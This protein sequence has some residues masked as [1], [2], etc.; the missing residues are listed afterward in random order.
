[1]EVETAV[2]GSCVRVLA[3]PEQGEPDVSAPLRKKATLLV[4]VYRGGDWSGEVTVVA[5]S[6]SDCAEDG[7]VGAFLIQSQSVT[8]AFPADGVEELTL[9]IKA[10]DEDADGHPAGAEDCDDRDPEVFVGN[11]AERCTDSKDKNCSGT[12]GCADST[13]TGGCD[14]G[15]ACTTSDQCQPGGTCS[16]SA[17][18]C[19]SPPVC[20]GAPGTCDPSDGGCVYPALAVSTA[21]NDNNACSQN[22]VCQ[23]DAT[24]GGGTAVTCTAP[25]ECVVATCNLAS[26]CQFAPGNENVVC[27]GGKG[28]CLAGTCAFNGFVTPGTSNFTA[29]GGLPLG[30]VT[31]NCLSTLDTAGATPTWTLCNGGQISSLDGGVRILVQQSG[32]EAVL[33]RVNDFSLTDAGV[34]RIRGTRPVIL[35]VYGDALIGGEVD[36]GADALPAAGADVACNP[37]VNGDRTAAQ[38][39]GGGGGGAFAADGGAGGRGAN[40]TP[41]GLG[42]TASGIAI[43]VPLRGGCGGGLGGA[44]LPDKSPGGFGGGALQLSAS[45]VVRVTGIINANGGGGAGAKQRAV[46]EDDADGAGGGGS[47]GAILLEGGYVV[48]GA[49]SMLLAN[50]GTGGEGGDGYSTGP[51]VDGVGGKRGYGPTAA[52]TGR[53]DGGTDGAAGG[54]GDVIEGQSAADAVDVA[55]LGSPGGG[56]GGGSAGRIRINFAALCRESGYL[57]SPA[58]PLMDVNAAFTASGA[59]PPP[60]A[61][62]P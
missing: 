1:M 20:R 32:I 15:N 52:P 39:E 4:A 55:G 17:V 58:S 27:N 34:L 2:P 5:R 11:P 41:V 43:L 26:G 29:D 33:V 62:C 13:C 37:A 19:G 57:V 46:M 60:T 36:L 10:P 9:R 24:C 3:T 31:I 40:S 23:S 54:G 50:G 6:Y 51:G 42:G 35:A 47:G 48:L 49:T 22:E 59:L 21:C 44:I 28:V 61:R 14:D 8:A 18:S 30:P 38:G 16:G 7:D 25:N 12:V 53:L 45:G 56:G